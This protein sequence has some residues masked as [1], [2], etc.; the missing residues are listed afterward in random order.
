MNNSE[1]LKKLDENHRLMLEIRSRILRLHN[2]INTQILP[3]LTAPP[4][5]DVN[6]ISGSSESFSD[7]L[8]HEGIN[9]VC[10][11]GSVREMRRSKSFGK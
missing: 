7:P 9:E 11:S 10:V 8:S 6:S 4:S 1:Y 2:K 5:L 3:S